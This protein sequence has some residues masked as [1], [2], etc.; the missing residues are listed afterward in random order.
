[1][2]IAGTV[3]AAA[4]LLGDWRD[5]GAGQPLIP[6]IAR[7]RTW[8]KRHVLRRKTEVHA[9]SAHAGTSWGVATS[10]EGYAAPPANAPVDV[11]M[12]FVR[13]RLLVL[14]HR[15][16]KEREAVDQK[17][18]RVQADGQ[19]A[20]SR[21]QAAIDELESKVREVATGSVRLELLG[22]VLVG[23]G[24]IVSTLPAVCGWL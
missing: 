4:A 11:Q 5:H 3:L 14:E 23:A 12:R 9:V 15:I 17:I 19:A 1:M 16:A 13:E 20:A 22:L 6:A 8:F 21:S 18:A 2:T 7:L 24:S 10:A